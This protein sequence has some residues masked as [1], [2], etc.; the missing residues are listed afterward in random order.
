VR[1]VRIDE[2][3]K[4][5]GDP[6]DA[7]DADAT[8]LLALRDKL[9]AAATELGRHRR[10]IV[11]ATLDGESLRAS[12]R[13]TILV[14]RLIATMAPVAQE[15]AARSQSAGEL[16]L[17]RLLADDR[18]E[19]VFLSK[20]EL[21]RKLEPLAEGE[22]GLFDRLLVDTGIRKEPAPS[23]A[24]PPVTDKLAPLVRPSRA[25][26]PLSGV[27]SAGAIPGLPIPTGSGTPP[28]PAEAPRVSLKARLSASVP[29]RRDTPT[30]P[31]PAIAPALPSPIE[32]PPPPEPRPKAGTPLSG[33]PIEAPP[34]PTAPVGPPGEA[35]Q[36]KEIDPTPP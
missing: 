26:T 23:A 20:G 29:L 2:H 32:P 19:E 14:E 33:V 12:N 31:G 16:V 25:A 5:S 10:A 18:R 35:V 7:Q 24:K 9:T 36:A 17:R 3:G 11:E 6:F 4:P 15:I 8:K 1:L 22:R 13:S 21:R 34:T 30:N 28:P 27:I